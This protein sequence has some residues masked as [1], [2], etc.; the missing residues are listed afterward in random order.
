LLIVALFSVSLSLIALL[1][2]LFLL[3]SLSLLPTTT[4]ILLQQVFYSP[5]WHKKNALFRGKSLAK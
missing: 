2:L 5:A 1:L 4:I 3:L